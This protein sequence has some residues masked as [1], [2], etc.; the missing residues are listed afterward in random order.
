MGMPIGKQSERSES[1]TKSVE[2]AT[3][4]V[5]SK[6]LRTKSSTPSIVHTGSTS[7]RQVTDSSQE[8]LEHRRSSL[9]FS[10]GESD[11]GKKPKSS[12]PSIV[13]TAST[14]AQE[15]TDRSQE[16]LQYMRSS[17]GFSEDKHVAGFNA[18]LDLL[19]IDSAVDSLTV[20]DMGKK[21]AVVT[22]SPSDFES[23]IA[24]CQCAVEAALAA[25]ASGDVSFTAQELFIIRSVAQHGLSGDNCAI[26]VHSLFTAL[27][28]DVDAK[29]DKDIVYTHTSPRKLSELENHSLFV[30][31]KA[32]SENTARLLVHEALEVRKKYPRC[33]DRNGGK[34]NKKNKSKQCATQPY[35]NK[36][37]NFRICCAP[38]VI[39]AAHGAQEVV[40]FGAVPIKQ[41]TLLC[42]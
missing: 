33:H 3:P 22:C 1:K 10:E 40:I 18:I 23:F 8:H 13:H 36:G 16:H 31:M 14:S 38:I 41:S 15:A 32:N 2:R 17:L 6:K 21:I 29:Q 30:G 7:A 24:L 11:E 34:E 9:G 26:M 28:R 5:K 27:R 42:A 20:N 19:Q 12:T 39:L 37:T 4:Y 35:Q 25:A